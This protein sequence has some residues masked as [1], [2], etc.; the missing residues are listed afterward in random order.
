MP[1][2]VKQAVREVGVEQT[3]YTALTDDI[4]RAS[5]R[6]STPSRVAS[7]ERLG[8]A[9]GHGRKKETHPC[10]G[11]SNAR[12]ESCSESES[13]RATLCVV[14]QLSCKPS[15]TNRR[16]SICHIGPSSRRPSSSLPAGFNRVVALLL[17]CSIQDILYITRVQ[18]ERFESEEAYEAVKGSYTVNAKT[19][20]KAKKHMAVMHPLP[21]VDEL[22]EDV[23][24]DPRA[25][26][27]RQMTNGMYVRMVRGRVSCLGAALCIFFPTSFLFVLVYA[28]SSSSFTAAV[29]FPEKWLR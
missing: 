26:Y 1:V 23:D 28:G 11:V 3:E 20:S 27:F 9:C 25:A 15:Q 12:I 24:S 2:E 21:R 4:V 18:K 10:A 22:A 14:K 13:D 8:A 19:L 5:V 16:H 29:K 6:C 7:T 17:R